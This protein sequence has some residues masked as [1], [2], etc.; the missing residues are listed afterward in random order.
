MKFAI[1]V[2]SQ[3]CKVVLFSSII[4]GQAM[5]GRKSVVLEHGGYNGFLAFGMGGEVKSNLDLNLLYGFTPKDLAGREIHTLNFKS[6]FYL[7][8]IGQRYQMMLRPKVGVGVLYGL[9]QD[10]FLKLPSQYP[11][12]YYPPSALRV[13]LV[14]GIEL[15]VWNQFGV[16]LEYNLLD[17]ELP[18]LQEGG[19][20]NSKMVGSSAISM[21]FYLD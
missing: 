3:V 4:A 2:V 21:R 8:S 12:N 18:L 20:V 17:T 16:G 15:K 10:L 14:L 6:N 11:D 19:I 13:I 9:S 7:A 1:K 5:G